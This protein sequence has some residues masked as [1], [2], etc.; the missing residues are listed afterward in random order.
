MRSVNSYQDIKTPEDEEYDDL[1]EAC[2]NE[3]CALYADEIAE[4]GMKPQNKAMLMVRA[5]KIAR[6]RMESA[7]NSQEE[8]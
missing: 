2:Y 5:R 3:L 8:I 6:K 7:Q 4:H 1:V